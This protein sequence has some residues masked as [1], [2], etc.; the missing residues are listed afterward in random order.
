MRSAVS[1]DAQS[2]MPTQVTSLELVNVQLTNPIYLVD[3]TEECVVRVPRT[4]VWF[5]REM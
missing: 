4:P 5:L 2:L 3:L 1:T